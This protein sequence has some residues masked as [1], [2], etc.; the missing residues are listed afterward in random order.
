MLPSYIGSII[1]HYKNP[2]QPTSIMES[3]GSHVVANPTLTCLGQRS[4]I[5][6]QPGYVD[7]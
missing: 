2:Y 4:E 1:N 5:V 3:R 6:K 7:G